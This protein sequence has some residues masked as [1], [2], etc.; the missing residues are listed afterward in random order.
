MLESPDSK[1][2]NYY[3]DTQVRGL[4]ISVAR[5]GTKTFILRKKIEGRSERIT[6]G[7]YPDISLEEARK[8]AYEARTKIA[9]GVNPAETKRKAKEELTLEDLFLEYL[10]RHADKQ[11]KTGGDMRK[12]FERYLGHW[13]ERK[14]SKIARKEVERLHGSLAREKGIHTANRTIQM[15]RAIYNKAITWHLFDLENPAAGIS[16][17]PE[18]PRERFL[19]KEEATRLLRALEEESNKDLAD[20]VKLSFFTGIRKS[21][22]MALRW[23]WIDWKTGK[24]TIPDTKNNTKQVLALG[25]WEIAILQKRFDQLANSSRKA[26][27]PMSD[28]VF[29]GTGKDGH[30]KDLKRSW[31]SFRLRNGMED[32]TIH[33]LRRSLA[34]T[35]ANA[36]MN[37]SLVKSALNHKDIKTTLAVYAR[38][39]DEAVRDAR[40]QALTP[41]LR[42]S[43]ILD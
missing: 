8:L 13:K 15:L 21:N 10:E 3:A 14:A 11:R 38:T 16:L 35:M 5:G 4:Y 37:L 26:K 25:G 41:I 28:F 9:N 23:D 30:L 22:L 34:A 40:E 33:D 17:F 7:V 19:S 31:T 6:L 20:F 42:D 32:I 18:K 29:P 36:N 39:Q 1:K 27:V 12:N 24:L 2:Q 43:G